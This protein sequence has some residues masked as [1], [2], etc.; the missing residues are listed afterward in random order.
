LDWE[1]DPN[2]AANCRLALVE[3]VDLFTDGQVTI[4]YGFAENLLCAARAT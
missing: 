1:P 2:H 4:L 3:M